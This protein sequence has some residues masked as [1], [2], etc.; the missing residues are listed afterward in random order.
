MKTKFV[1]LILISLIAGLV[2]INAP[3]ACYSTMPQETERSRYVPPFL[4]GKN[5]SKSHG[6]FSLET[7]PLKEMTTYSGERLDGYR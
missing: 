1:L 7:S 4:V 2:V 3:R 5:G 6:R